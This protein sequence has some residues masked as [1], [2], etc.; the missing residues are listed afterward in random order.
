MCMWQGGECDKD[1]THVE[2]FPFSEPIPAHDSFPEVL[3]VWVH[4]C[5]EHCNSDAL[6]NG[7]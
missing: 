7:A 3:G 5:D 4:V 1:A 2:M 6:H